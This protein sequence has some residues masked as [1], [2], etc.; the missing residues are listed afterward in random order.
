MCA[1]VH[2]TCAC[3]RACLYVGVSV[4]C[5][6]CIRVYVYV[7]CVD[8]C[9]HVC[10][11]VCV[12]VC[13]HSHTC[14]HTH[15]LSLSLFLLCVSSGKAGN[16]G[17]ETRDNGARAAQNNDE[18]TL[19]STLKYLQMLRGGDDQTQESASLCHA[20]MGGGPAE[21]FRANGVSG[22]EAV[23]PA[24]HWNAPVLTVG[25]EREKLRSACV[26]RLQV[27]D[28][29]FPVWSSASAENDLF[30]VDDRDKELPNLRMHMAE[31]LSNMQHAVQHLDSSHRGGE[32]RG[33]QYQ[34]PVARRD[35]RSR[36]HR[37]S[38]QPDTSAW[39]TRQDELDQLENS[40]HEVDYG[41]EVCVF[42]YQCAASRYQTA[43]HLL[44]L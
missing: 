14:M 44:A 10:V 27:E 37:P 39:K 41:M 21:H 30:D 26:D 25:R 35:S 9:V 18:N 23:P 17:H 31:M 3:V 34:D 19:A 7:L 20:P 12:Y 29:Y 38:Q 15:T 8:M 1:H 24:M 32:G 16:M 6:H 28:M 4:R 36:G 40:L 43:S 42:L 11:Y 22:W 5:A 2:N 13:T 33:F